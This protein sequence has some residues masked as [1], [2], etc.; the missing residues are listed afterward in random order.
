[1]EKSW[2]QEKSREI[3]GLISVLKGNYCIGNVGKD[4]FY[5]CLQQIGE[6][7]V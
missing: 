5:F 1:M 2:N 3:I 4:S 7:L 6:R